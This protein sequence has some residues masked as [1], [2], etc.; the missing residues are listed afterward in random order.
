MT[1]ALTPAAL[2]ALQHSIQS[3]H[4]LSEST[5]LTDFSFGHGLLAPEL[6][7]GSLHT[8]RLTNAH[9]SDPI[10][11]LRPFQSFWIYQR[12]VASRASWLAQT[13]LQRSQFASNRTLVVAVAKQLQY[14]GSIRCRRCRAG[15]RALKL[16]QQCALEAENPETPPTG[17]VHQRARWDTLAWAVT[18]ARDAV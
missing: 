6:Q 1:S 5:V 13:P 9:L 16:R 2:L 11:A 15:L 3:Q 18:P 12:A 8:W 7:R 14:T 4:L 17:G 10:P